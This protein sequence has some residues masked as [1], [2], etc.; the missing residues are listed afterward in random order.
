MKDSEPG[1]IDFFSLHFNA[2]GYSFKSLA[3]APA[4]SFAF[5]FGF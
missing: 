4:N 2:S 3:M 1:K 5:G